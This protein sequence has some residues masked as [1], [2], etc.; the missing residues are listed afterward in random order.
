M[1]EQQINASRDHYLNVRFKTDKK[2]PIL[3]SSA[4]KYIL[5]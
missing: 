4:Q 3:F 2:D 1:Y 5:F